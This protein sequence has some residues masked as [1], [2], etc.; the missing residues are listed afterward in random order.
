[1]SADVTKAI[2]RLLA[3]YGEPKTDETEI[4]FEEFAK[5]LTGFRADI[6]AKGVDAV[7]KDRA[8]SNW[9]TVGE[10][11]QACRDASEAMADRYEPQKQVYRKS[12]PVPEAV[13]RA[14]LEGFNKTMTAGNAFADI[15]ARMPREAGA[16]IDVSRPWGEEVHD[17]WGNIVPIRKRNAA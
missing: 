16:T 7:I 11:V 3:V 12:D 9:P 15:V 8:F 13:A 17:A 14:L 2:R 10:V 5:A 6:L 4:L 1:M